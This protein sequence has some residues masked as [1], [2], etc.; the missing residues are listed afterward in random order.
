LKIDNI[1]PEKEVHLSAVSNACTERLNASLI[2]EEGKK[3]LLGVTLRK[4]WSAALIPQSCCTK[5][6]ISPIIG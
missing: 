5:R 2:R 1:F 4:E 6:S 3:I